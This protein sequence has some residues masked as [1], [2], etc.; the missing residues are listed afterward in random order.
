MKSFKNYTMIVYGLYALGLFLGGVPTVIGLIVAYL[1]RKEYSGTIYAEHLS[2]LIRTFWYGVLW[3]I[4]A[5]I[6]ALVYIGFIVMFVVGIW[7]IYRIV[8]GFL[9]LNDGKGIW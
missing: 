2:F 6:L 7:Y 5:L 4:V 3:S 1:K 9:Y 8:R